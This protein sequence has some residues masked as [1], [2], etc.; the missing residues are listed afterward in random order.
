MADE[1]MAVRTVLAPAKLTVSLSVGPVR[2]DGYHEIDAE[3]VTLNL[4]DELAFDDGGSGITVVADDDVR[5]SDFPAP[6]D[7]LVAR[8]LA[9]CR[10]TAGIRL[11]K[12]IPLGAGLGGGSADAAA[13]LR[14]A[15]NTDPEAA[16]RLGSDV[17][18]CVVGGRARVQGVG[19][20]VT[21]LPFEECQY[22][23]LLPPFGVD[24]GE[25]YR[26]WDR[27]E[28]AGATSGG[29][30]PGIGGD[31][32]AGTN[33]LTGAALAVEP[34]LAR[35]REAFGDLTGCQPTLAGSG[36]T[37]FVTGGPTEAGTPAMPVLRIGA[38]SARLVRVSAVPAGW[39]GR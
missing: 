31:Q 35:W 33:A 7:N 8:A 9:S 11:T 21:P 32:G 17:P 3:M 4:A 23:L 16:A 30:G 26:A 34:R 6:S 24:T 20:R 18:F 39:K 27:L 22:L 19:E 29:P 28:V 25:V 38:E 12:R 10:R 36:S 15:E 5:V 2:D 37:W 14:W 13:V 1:K